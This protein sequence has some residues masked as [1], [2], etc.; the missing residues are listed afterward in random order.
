MGVPGVTMKVIYSSLQEIT[1]PTRYAFLLSFTK[2]DSP[3]ADCTAMSQALGNCD[4]DV[5]PFVDITEEEL[6]E[7]LKHIRSINQLHIFLHIS[8]HGFHCTENKDT[9]IIFRGG[10]EIA[11]KQIIG[12]IIEILGEDNKVFLTI[13]ASRGWETRE[14][15]DEEQT[16]LPLY[17]CQRGEYN[18]PGA[19]SVFLEA[20]SSNITTGMT[21]RRF[22]G[23]VE[24]RMEIE[25][26][27]SP[28]TEMQWHSPAFLE[29]TFF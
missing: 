4:F 26:R 9:F 5:K 18:A 1:P 11:V 22:C 20:V 16:A 7:N 15:I 2:E 21:V 8:G 25:D 6:K 12:K 27:G 23:E 14:K 24:S 13:D 10:E 29:S 19:S 3:P 17:S 28:T